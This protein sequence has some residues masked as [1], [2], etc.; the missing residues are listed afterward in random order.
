MVGCGTIRLL[1]WHK[2]IHAAVATVDTFEGGGVTA[3]GGDGGGRGN[4][5][6]PSRHA[7]VFI[8]FL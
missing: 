2:R 1:E 8:E 4:V 6:A 7:K 3:G 5:A